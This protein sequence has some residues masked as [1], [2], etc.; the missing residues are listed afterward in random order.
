MEVWAHRG[1]V[2]PA[3]EN[4]LEAFDAALKAGANGIECDVRLCGSGEVI[5]MHDS[6]LWRTDNKFIP[7]TITSLEEL[8]EKCSYY[9][10]T[11]KEVLDKYASKTKITLDLKGTRIR[12]SELEKKVVN[13]IEE[14][15]HSHNIIVSCFNV[16]SLCKVAALNS[17]IKVA[18]IVEDWLSV[19][20]F[21]PLVFALDAVH[22]SEKLATRPRIKFWKRQ[23]L[24][25]RVWTVNGSETAI[26]LAKNGVSAIISDN[27][28]LFG[29]GD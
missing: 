20:R 15:E 8:R 9:I 3:V 26:D 7:V 4:T 13:L 23:G 12:N 28:K 17:T 24:Q 10:P 5:L 2:G 1:L 27:G 14:C 21:L 22:L 25:V 16:L 6:I 29:K 19:S 18:L 11:L